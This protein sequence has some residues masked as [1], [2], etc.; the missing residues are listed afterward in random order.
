ENHTPLYVDVDSARLWN[1]V[2]DETVH[3][4]LKKP[5]LLELARRRDPNL[6]DYCENLLGSGE[7][8]NWLTSISTLVALGTPEAVDRLIL[9]YAQSLNDE[10]KLV[11][12]MVA[13][14]LTADYVK[15]FSIM[16]REVAV[17]G[18][19]D[20][21]GWTKIAI[22]TLRDVCKRFGVEVHGVYIGSDEDMSTVS[23]DSPNLDKITTLPDK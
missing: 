1:L 20:V 2:H 13:K 10:R 18:E 15:P 7:Y 19:L 5:A 14:V 11:L 21:S 3:P 17:P 4:I 16:V 23:P 12:C 9:V 22:S 8:E 6:M